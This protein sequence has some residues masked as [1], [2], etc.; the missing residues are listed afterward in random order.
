MPAK[1]FTPDYVPRPPVRGWRRSKPKTLTFTFSTPAQGPFRS[2]ARRW[3]T[4]ESS[5]FIEG[6]EPDRTTYL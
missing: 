1:A 3:K 4:L 6:I 2:P 5:R